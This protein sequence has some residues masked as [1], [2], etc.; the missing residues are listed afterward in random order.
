MSELFGATNVVFHDP[1]LF[2]AEL[3]LLRTRWTCVGTTFDLPGPDTHFVH[4][5]SQRS[6]IVAR[7]AEGR[8]GAFVNAC[9]HRGTRLC[10]GRGAGKIQCPYHGWVFGSDG[11]LLGASK[12][13]GFAELDESTLGLARVAAVQLGK[14]IF[15]HDDPT[16]T[17]ADLR[18]FLGEEADEIAAISE[19]AQRPL[20][21]CRMPLKGNWK[22]A[23]S[24]AIEDYHVPFVHKQT[25]Q[26]GRK[27]TPDDYL[28]REHGHAVFSTAAPLGWKKPLLR[29]LGGIEPLE[30][31]ESHFV[32]PNLLVIQIVGVIHV[33]RFV[34]V[35]PG[36]TLRVSQLYDISPPRGWWHPLEWLRWAIMPLARKGIHK[37]F[38]EDRAVLEEAQIG[39]GVAPDLRRG[40]AHMEEARVEH[41]LGEVQ[42][43]VNAPRQLPLASSSVASASA[44]PPG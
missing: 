8:L 19:K 27:S 6:L 31:F 18:A 22:L 15:V 40:P 36:E 4:E 41:F 20:L 11:R 32:F 12:R 33:T 7:D 16:Q 43:L 5:D 2:E 35:A 24:G 39:T 25:L 21:E 37:V 26:K 1:A 44:T 28:L 38:H 29:W 14:L 13:A 10:Q 34:P 42:R 23:V 17:E 3:G 9:T 30:Q